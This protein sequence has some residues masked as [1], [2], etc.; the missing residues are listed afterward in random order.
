MGSSVQMGSCR[1]EGSVQEAAADEQQ[2]AGGS[3]KREELQVECSAAWYSCRWSNN[4]VELAGGAAVV[5]IELQVK[6]Q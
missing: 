5:Q 2:C 1:C 6:L 4:G 3:C